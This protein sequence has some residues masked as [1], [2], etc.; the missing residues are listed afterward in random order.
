MTVFFI[1]GGSMNI[2][3]EKPEE[4]KITSQGELVEHLLN[5][6]GDVDE[7]SEENRREMDAQIMAKLK[8]GKS[9]RKRN[10]IISGE[11]TPYF[12]LRQ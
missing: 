11:Q 7:M 12:M 10:W 2:F 5:N 6:S 3:F 9:F 8:S 1:S 4:Q